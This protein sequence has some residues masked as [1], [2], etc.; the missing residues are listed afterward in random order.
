[1]AK[2][3]RTATPVELLKP[4]QCIEIDNQHILRISKIEPCMVRKPENGTP[5]VLVGWLLST[6]NNTVQ[7]FFE[8]HALVDLVDESTLTQVPFD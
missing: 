3:G 8:D 1:M 2:R 7:L 6:Y 5:I 4:H